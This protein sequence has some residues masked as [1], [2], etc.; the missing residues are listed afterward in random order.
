MRDDGISAEPYIVIPNWDKLT[1][2]HTG[3]NY[4]ERPF[5]TKRHA[6]LLDEGHYLRLTF[7]VR[8]LYHDIVSAYAKTGG[9]L[10]ANPKELGSRLGVTVKQASLDALSDAG[11][12]VIRP[13]NVLGQNREEEIRE[14]QELSVADKSASPLAGEAAIEEQQSKGEALN[15][16]S[17]VVTR[18]WSYWISQL[19]GCDAGTLASFRLRLGDDFERVTPALLAQAMRA[20]LNKREEGEIESEPAYFVGIVG[21]LLNPLGDEADIHDYR[22]RFGE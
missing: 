1:Q 4:N 8:G 19:D 5:W 10:S 18:L 22:E 11:L 21:N 20:F 7:A 6:V 9:N 13:R 14:E 15:G 2:Y 17:A 16:G 12:I 3:K